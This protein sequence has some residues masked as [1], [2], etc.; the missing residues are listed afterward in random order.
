MISQEKKNLWRQKERFFGNIYSGFALMA[1]LY[2]VR[3]SQFYWH[4]WANLVM[5]ICSNFDT[6]QHGKNDVFTKMSVESWKSYIVFLRTCNLTRVGTLVLVIHDCDD[7]FLEVTHLVSTL[8]GQIFF[9]VK[10]LKVLFLSVPLTIKTI[11]AIIIWSYIRR[12]GRFCF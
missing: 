9:L 1:F 8:P 12:W 11:F 7:I 6:K 4:F 2:Y 5:W 10:S 3:F